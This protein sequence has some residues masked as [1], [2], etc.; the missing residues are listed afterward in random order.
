MAS[1]ELMNGALD[2]IKRQPITD[3]AER[4]DLLRQYTLISR[5]WLQEGMWTFNTI[6]VPLSGIE[7]PKDAYLFG[8]EYAYA[9]PNTP[10]VLRV[11]DGHNKRTSYKLA[12]YQ[13]PGSLK[14]TKAVFTNHDFF[15]LIYGGAVDEGFWTPTFSEAFVSRL[16]LQYAQMLTGSA[17]LIAQLKTEWL[18]KRSEALRVD[19]FQAPPERI[20]TNTD[21]LVARFRGSLAHMD[22]FL[23]EAGEGTP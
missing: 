9:Y 7:T 19:A 23:V 1:L 20:T 10:E 4:S 15:N 3:T 2:R 22:P 13:E 16:A 17:Q 5:S 21:F 14:L 12:L 6:T 11:Y 8:Y 18:E